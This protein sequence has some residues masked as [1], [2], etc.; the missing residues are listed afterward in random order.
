VDAHIPITLA[1]T[2][3]A[4][5][6]AARAALA[7]V[8]AARPSGSSGHMAIAEVARDAAGSLRVIRHETTMT[9]V[10]WGRALLGA[11]LVLVAPAAGARFV[12]SV[13]AVGGAGAVAG[14]LD[15]TI[16]RKDRD[17]AARLLEQH[18]TGLVVLAVNRRP[19]DVEPLLVSADE[20]FAMESVWN[21]L[22]R[23]IEQEIA[24]AQANPSGT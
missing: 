5:P 3:H 14:H 1:V 9:N 20:T 16:P 4:H 21:G 13:P 23:A 8:W 6:D 17:R 12:S 10:A 7:A 2:V 22:D 11:A 18:K 24:E 19:A 15:R